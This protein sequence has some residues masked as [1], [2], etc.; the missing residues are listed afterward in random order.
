LASLVATNQ[1][2]G[3]EGLADSVLSNAGPAMK[4][5]SLKL[6][7]RHVKASSLLAQALDE[8]TG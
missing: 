3:I 2:I 4:L 5:F 6:F 7:R 1:F 8:V